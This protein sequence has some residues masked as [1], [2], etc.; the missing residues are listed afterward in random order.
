VQLVN[1]LLTIALTAITGIAL[2]ACGS[3]ASSGAPSREASQ[4]ASQ[5]ESS[6]G[7]PLPS[8]TAGAVADLEALI[9]DTVGDMTISKQSMQGSEFLT[10]PGSDPAAVKFVEDL[11][12]SASDISIATGQGNNADFTKFVF[13][14][15]IRASGVDSDRL[16]SAFKTA[17]ATGDASPLSWS[18]ATVAGKSVET[19]EAG[20][21]ANYI[22]AKGDVMFWVIASDATVAEQ[23]IGLLP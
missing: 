9:P 1:R 5:A 23:F 17:S 13:V 6:G 12:V 22:Y 18:D 8:F 3:A 21:G 16:V 19:A 15:V 14:F 2:V 4:A 7:G 11:G 10:A 20:G